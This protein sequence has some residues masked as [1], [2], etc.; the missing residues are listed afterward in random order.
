MKKRSQLQ[1]FYATKSTEDLQ[2]IIT[3]N[4]EKLQGCIPQLSDF[5]R[6][7]IYLAKNELKTR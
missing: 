2:K 4:S 5:Y 1:K 3:E 6:N 7:Q